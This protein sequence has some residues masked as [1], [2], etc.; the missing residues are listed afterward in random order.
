MHQLMNWGCS[1]FLSIVNAAAVNILLVTE[2][3]QFL[4]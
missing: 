2:W 1:Q 4:K 3:A